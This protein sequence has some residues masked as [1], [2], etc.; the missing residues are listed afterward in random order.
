MGGAFVSTEGETQEE[1]K[2]KMEPEQV[3]AKKL[4]LIERAKDLF[5]DEP[6]KVWVFAIWFHS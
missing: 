6:R 2:A 3:K 4:G 1:A 5:Y